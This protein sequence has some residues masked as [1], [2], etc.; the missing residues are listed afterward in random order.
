MVASSTRML[1][2]LHLK[3][4]ISDFGAINHMNCDPILVKDFHKFTQ[5]V[6]LVADGNTAQA[7]G[8]GSITVTNTI[9]LDSVL[10]VPVL[11]YNLFI[12]WKNF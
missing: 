11:N 6:I 1:Y 10:A 7:I 8:E 3:L 5:S 2:I 4:W 12:Y 9:T